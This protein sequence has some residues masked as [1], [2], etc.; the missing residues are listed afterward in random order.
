[1]TCIWRFSKLYVCYL[2]RK[3]KCKVLVFGVKHKH[4]SHVGIYFPQENSNSKIFKI[5]S[6]TTKSSIQLHLYYF[7]IIPNFS[8]SV[9]GNL[10][11]NFI[12]F[13][14][15]LIFQMYLN[16]LINEN[17]FSTFCHTHIHALTHLLIHS[18]TELLICVLNFYKYLCNKLKWYLCDCIKNCM[19]SC[20]SHM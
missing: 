12:K 16:A 11:S 9:F 10:S 20:G 18:L 7:W 3:K 15:L 17:I 5:F 4:Q 6:Q 19:C 8:Y 2:K 13:I 14:S 1:M